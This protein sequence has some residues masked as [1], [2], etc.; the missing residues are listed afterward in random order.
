V[1]GAVAVEVP[2]TDGPAAQALLDRL[3]R[4]EAE[5]GRK[6][7]TR[8]GARTLDLDLLGLDDLVAPDAGTFAHWHG[9]SPD[10]QARAAPDRLV[11]P[12]PRI[13]DRAFVLVPLAD[14]APHWRH[15][16]LQLTTLDMLGRIGPG[17]I[18]EIAPVG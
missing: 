7:E 17:E 10:L 14:I 15:P 18:G 5:F 12:H 6:R 13:Q 16:V 2:H 1:N 9:L 4:I 11:V 8:W 3:H